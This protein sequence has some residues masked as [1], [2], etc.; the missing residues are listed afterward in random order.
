[1]IMAVKLRAKQ[2]L[3][4]WSYSPLLR[5]HICKLTNQKYFPPHNPESY[6]DQ[7]MKLC[8][9]VFTIVIVAVAFTLAEV[10]DC[11]HLKRAAH[12]CI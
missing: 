1:M 11:I 2:N 7:M 10:S 5:T 8:F 4:N 3:S 6:A 9:T 12:L